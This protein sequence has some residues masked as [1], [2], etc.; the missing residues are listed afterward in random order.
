M[1]F[2][3]LVRE[4]RH[5]LTDV[6]RRSLHSSNVGGS[7]SPRGLD[8]G[9][10][11]CPTPP[12]CPTVPAIWGTSPS[13]NS[14]SLVG[15]TKGK[16]ATIGTQVACGVVAAPLFV[17]AFTAIGAKRPGYDWRRDPVSSL[18]IGEQGWPQRA[19]FGLAGVLYL[20]AAL[21]LRKCPRRNVGPRAVPAL[22]AA[23]G[24]G[25]IGSG[26]FVT[27]PLDG[28]PPVIPGEGGPKSTR[29]GKLHKLFA[30]PIF[31]GLPVAALASAFGASRRGNVRWGG[32][33]AFSGI[34]MVA[35]IV[36]FGAAFGPESRL[37]GRGGVFQRISIASGFGWL[38]V[39]SLRA[40]SSLRHA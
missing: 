23:A 40:L 27:D 15:I 4:L 12:M 10:L 14:I 39:L 16:R 1:E 38:T 29:E 25:L 3:A 9:A 37:T 18:G 34:A 20:L 21:G 33:S 31:A 32:Y 24:V 19:N 17:T 30:I 7:G 13:C 28:F 8:S 36:A 22:V 6:A 11:G 2:W 26:L 5:S 35:S